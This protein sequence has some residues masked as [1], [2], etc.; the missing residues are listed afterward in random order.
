MVKLKKV[1]ALF[2]AFSTHLCMQTLWSIQKLEEGKAWELGYEKRDSFSYA[3]HPR[4]G[5]AEYLHL[6]AE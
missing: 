6:N 4:T 1:V 5:N 3:F 2:L